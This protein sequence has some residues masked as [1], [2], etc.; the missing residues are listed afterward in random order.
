MSIAVGSVLLRVLSWEAKFDAIEL[1]SL[2]AVWVTCMLPWTA[3]MLLCQVFIWLISGL[4]SS[5]TEADEPS[6]A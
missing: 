1:I 2:T 6:P 5:E 3:L 4:R